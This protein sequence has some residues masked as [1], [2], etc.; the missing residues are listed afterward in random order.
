MHLGGVPWAGSASRSATTTS[1][2][3][4]ASTR[5]SS[6]TRPSSTT[7]RRCDD[8]RGEGCRP[9]DPRS[10][11]LV[12]GS[13]SPLR[14]GAARS[15]L[16]RVQRSKCHFAPARVG[17]QAGFNCVT[18]WRS[19]PIPGGRT[20]SSHVGTDLGARQG[21]KLARLSPGVRV[22]CLPRCYPAHKTCRLAG[23]FESTYAP[24]HRTVSRALHSRSWRLLIRRT[25]AR[26]ARIVVRFLLDPFEVCAHPAVVRKRRDRELRD[27]EHAFVLR[28]LDVIKGGR[29]RTVSLDQPVAT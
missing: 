11:L 14:P 16:A 18:Y 28:H 23:A 1:P 2:R 8:S 6:P 4:A 22:R 9:L 15:L 3:R 20:R 10:G 27:A 17:R 21:P 13:P 24:S 5:M 29:W 19:S 26:L 12:E 25:S 7:R